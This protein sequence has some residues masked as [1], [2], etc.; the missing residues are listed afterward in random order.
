MDLK[1]RLASAEG[2]LVS[3][4]FDGTLAPITTRPEDA[5]LPPE[6]RERVAALAARR[7]VTV[8][9]VSGRVLSDVRERVGL[10]GL[11]YAGNHGLELLR[12]GRR[13]VH[14]I[15]RVR[16]PALRR[17]RDAIAER[18]AD[19]PGTWVEDKELTLTVHYREVDP[20]DREAVQRG[21]R[22]VVD[23]E[24]SLRVDPGKAVLEVLPDFPWGKGRAVS[25]LATGA[26]V[27]WLPMHVGDDTSDERAFRTLTDGVG[28]AVGGDATAA[29]ASLDG[30]EAVGQ[31]L[32]WLGEQWD[33][34]RR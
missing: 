25:L 15:A 20:D 17:A 5:T 27:G 22:R 34:T 26:G 33:V 23:G 30:P 31:F 1:A 24:P 9:V 16:R 29:D 10:D 18:V 19:V 32:A 7:D 4:D 14:P 28:V 8:A 3:L 12:N 13:V 11:A 21:V 6:R 2:L